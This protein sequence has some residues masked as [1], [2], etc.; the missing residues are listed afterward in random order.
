M[1]IS[2]QDSCAEVKLQ[3]GSSLVYWEA[4]S[5]G[6]VE[7][8]A[9]KPGEAPFPVAIDHFIKFGKWL[10]Y[11]LHFNHANIYSQYKW[12]HIYSYV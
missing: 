11:V 8:K 9:V 1:L 10:Q 3:D 4:G 12:M 6:K 5:G 7:L 2:Y